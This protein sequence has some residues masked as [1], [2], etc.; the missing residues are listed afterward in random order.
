MCLHV[1]DRWKRGA[2]NISPGD[3]DVMESSYIKYHTYLALAL[4]NA[5]QHKDADYCKCL[6]YL[7]GLQDMFR[8]NIPTFGSL[9]ALESA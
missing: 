6:I 1:R 3:L 8:S 4:H 5:V 7:E 2:E 9:S